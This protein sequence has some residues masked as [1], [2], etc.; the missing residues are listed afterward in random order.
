MPET[1]GGLLKRFGSQLKGH[2]LCELA[3][4]ADVFVSLVYAQLA[5]LEPRSH[6]RVA[7]GRFSFA[8]LVLRCD[9]Y[10]PPSEH[11]RIFAGESSKNVRV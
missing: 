6:T 3:G 5:Y 1:S 4:T 8:L 11:G 9:I 2:D 7:T 10:R